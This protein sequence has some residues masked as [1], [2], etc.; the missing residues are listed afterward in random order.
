MKHRIV[1]ED[2][3]GNT[4]VLIPAPQAKLQIPD[5]IN[6]QL[7]LETDEEFATRIAAEDVPFGLSAALLTTRDLP[8]HRHFRN[9]WK[10]DFLN[11]AVTTDMPKA[12]NIHRDRIRSAREAKLAQLDVDYMRADEQGNNS[13][14]ALIAA[15]KQA[16]RDLPSS[17][18]IDTASTPEELKATWPAIL[19][20]P[21]ATN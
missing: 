5:I 17:P 21:Y 7:R 8:A 11:S 20:N 3:G 14:K 18:A 19:P 16:L 4:V 9:A 2:A 1:Y 6:G 13:L 15:E 10:F 12:R